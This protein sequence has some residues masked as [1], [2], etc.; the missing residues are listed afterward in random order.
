MPL[1]ED[2]VY[3]RQSVPQL[4]PTDQ[5]KAEE[6]ER[7]KV[8]NELPLIKEVIENFDKRIAL[9]SDITSIGVSIDDDP[10]LHQR[11]CVAYAMLADILRLEKAE[12]EALVTAYATKR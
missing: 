8:L 5:Q 7:I 2:N 12:L 10:V 1:L 11:K 6:A 9:C 3:R 4:V